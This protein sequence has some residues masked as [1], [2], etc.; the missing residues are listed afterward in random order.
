MQQLSSQKYQSISIFSIVK[1]SHSQ[2]SQLCSKNCLNWSHAHCSICNAHSHSLLKFSIP[3]FPIP[4]NAYTAQ[5]HHQ[6][7]ISSI[8]YYL[9][10][11]CRISVLFYGHL[12]L[13][14]TITI[15]HTLVLTLDTRKELRDSPARDTPHIVNLIVR[16]RNQVF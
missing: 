13:Y 15:Q 1:Y 16:Y 14:Y 12:E 7:S 5:P 11:F 2:L 10:S 9:H 4:Q 6:K 8:A 3:V